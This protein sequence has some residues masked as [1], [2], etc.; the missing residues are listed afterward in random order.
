MPRGVCV[1][2]AEC[3]V[4]RPAVMMAMNKPAAASI[5]QH[6][7]E[8]TPAGPH[9]PS[10]SV[11]LFPSPLR[12]RCVAIPVR[13]VSGD[14]M[15]LLMLLRPGGFHRNPMHES[16]HCPRPLGRRSSVAVDLPS[17]AGVEGTGAD[18]E[19]GAPSSRVPHCRIPLGCAWARTR[20]HRH[21]GLR[22]PPHGPNIPKLVSKATVT[23]LLRATEGPRPLGRLAF[24]LFPSL[25]PS[26]ARHRGRI[27]SAT[28]PPW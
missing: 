2:A 12:V 5:D 10:P 4:L 19:P 14:E 21:K 8:V 20:N 9:A 1:T 13:E 24:F 7:A 22:C 23:P 6:W 27:E 16:R 28:G 18:V 26:P 11:Y 17:A 25:A 3:V 15:F